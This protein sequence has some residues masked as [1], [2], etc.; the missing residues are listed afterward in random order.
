MCQLAR[1]DLGEQLYEPLWSVNEAN[2]NIR[3]PLALVKMYH[4]VP[5]KDML[6][7]NGHR[8][9]LVA[10]N[11]ATADWDAVE[12][13]AICGPNVLAFTSSVECLTQGRRLRSRN[14]GKITL[15]G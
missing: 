7:V 4:V 11:G 15:R 2:D 13:M 1:T 9:A 3:G 14:A 5:G 8:T 10:C 12:A 6:R